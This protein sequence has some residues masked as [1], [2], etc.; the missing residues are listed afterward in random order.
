MKKAIN[1]TFKNNREEQELYDWI[2]KHSNKS[3]FIKDIL[4]QYKQKEES[5][6][7]KVMKGFLRLED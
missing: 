5:K 2:C 4:S 1:L 6:D 7:K 3:G